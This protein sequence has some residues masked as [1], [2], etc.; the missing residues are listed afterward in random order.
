MRLAANSGPTTQSL[1]PIAGETT[2]KSIL[3]PLPTSPA[4]AKDRI[5][6]QVLL[7]R[8]GTYKLVVEELKSAQKVK[9]YRGIKDEAKKLAYSLLPNTRL[10]NRVA[11]EAVPRSTPMQFHAIDPKRFDKWLLDAGAASEALIA[12]VFFFDVKDINTANEHLRTS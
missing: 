6:V 8:N 11:V 5:H 12:R 9:Q 2:S 7:F 1:A 4:A 10:S 3:D